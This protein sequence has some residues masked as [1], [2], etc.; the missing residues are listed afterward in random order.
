ML[1]ITKIY[2]FIFG[3]LSIGGGVMGYVKAGSVASI[4]AGGT[5]GALLIAAGVLMSTRSQAG[6]ILGLVISLA[7][8]GR[9]L[10]IYLKTYAFMPAGLMAILGVI[11]AV[12]S[13]TCLVMKR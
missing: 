13:I 11:G 10:P 4:V 7:L 3:A 8:A 5:A 12:L 6:L 2:Y 1:D 9:F